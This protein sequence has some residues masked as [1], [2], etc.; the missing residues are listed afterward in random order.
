MAHDSQ[1]EQH[2]SYRLVYCTLRRKAL[3]QTSSGRKNTPVHPRTPII[4][5]TRFVFI[6]YAHPPFICAYLRSISQNP[7][8]PK[9]CSDSI[10]V[11]SSPLTPPSQAFQKP[12][13]ILPNT[14]PT[15]YP[16]LCLIRNCAP[17]E[18]SIEAKMQ[19]I[20]R[21]NSPK[22]SPDRLLFIRMGVGQQSFPSIRTHVMRKEIGGFSKV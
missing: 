17:S 19:I 21:F 18:T 1:T 10:E 11:P 7:V 15:L 8:I 9:S 2:L 12:R 14:S 4:T 20:P 3:Y 5:M 22:D 6:L 16:K 13:L